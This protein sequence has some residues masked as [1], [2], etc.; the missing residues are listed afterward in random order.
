M[1]QVF[2]KGSTGRPLVSSLC[3]YVFSSAHVSNV[4]LKHVV[5]GEER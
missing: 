3:T 4:D 5:L 2:G 1:H